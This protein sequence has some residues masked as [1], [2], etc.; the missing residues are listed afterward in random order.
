MRSLAHLIILIAINALAL[1]AA[2]TYIPGF[3]FE[4]LEPVSLAQLAFVFVILNAVAKPILKLILGP[5]IILTL[6]LGLIAVNALVL[7]L[8]DFFFENLSIETISALIWSTLLI[9]LVNFVFH[10]GTKPRHE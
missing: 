8:L 5:I 7:K 3:N 6:G 9:G 2:T 4:P 1:W 10:L